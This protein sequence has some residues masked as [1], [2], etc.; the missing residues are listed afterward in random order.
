MPRVVNE[1]EF[2]TR[3][4]EILDVA[5]RLVF[6]KGYEQMSIQDILDEMRISK[7][8]FYHY[9]SSK[10]DLLE[11][12]TQRIEAEAFNQL[13]PIL[14]EKNLSSLEKIERFFNSTARWKTANK[15]YLLA[16]LRVW[17]NDDNAILRQKMVERGFKRIMPL[18]ADAI[19]QGT[20][21]GVTSTSYSDPIGSV[22]ISLMLGMGDATAY[23]ILALRPDS[24]QIEREVCYRNMVEL[25]KAYTAAIERVLGAAPGAMVFF[26]LEI[27]R[28]WVL[29]LEIGDPLQT[30]V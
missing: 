22:L 15:A 17:Y 12:L 30:Q 16:I 10:P 23:E 28:E 8:A 9:F 4:N 6:S 18:L 21:E 29:P 11:A 25:V 7:G 2:A 27:L 20:E 19:R 24:G 5:Q 26:D 3:R 13:T 14:Q 1:E